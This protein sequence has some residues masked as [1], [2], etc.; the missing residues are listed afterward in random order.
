MC[1][2]TTEQ[3]IK[4][5]RTEKNSTCAAVGPPKPGHGHP[6]PGHQD[7]GLRLLLRRRGRGRR[8]SRLGRPAAAV[9]AGAGGRARL[10]PR[11]PGEVHGDG[12][13]PRCG[14]RVAIHQI[15]GTRE[16][17]RA[18]GRGGRKKELGGG[19]AWI[20]IR[21]SRFSPFV[22]VFGLWSRRPNS[23]CVIVKTVGTES[24]VDRIG[25]LLRS[26]RARPGSGLHRA[27]PFLALQDFPD[28]AM[29]RT[30]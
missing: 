22:R 20:W 4:Q 6:R 12:L 15:R 19:A 21:V 24:A 16:L 1:T 10:P 27:S 26:R 7:H 8:R 9:E 2:G 3:P 14:R 23:N 17:P 5:D 28:K 30:H 13:V 29:L 18:R 25:P 11:C